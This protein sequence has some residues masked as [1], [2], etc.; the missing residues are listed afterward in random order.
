MEKIY[1]QLPRKE[2]YP[3]ISELLFRLLGLPVNQMPWGEKGMLLKAGELLLS[4]HQELPGEGLRTRVCLQDSAGKSYL[5]Q[6]LEEDKQVLSSASAFTRR[7]QARAREGIFRVLVSAWGQLSPYGVLLGVRPTKLIHHF[8]HQGQ[9]LGQIET[10][11]QEIYCLAPEKVRLLLEVAGPIH[12]LLSSNSYQ[13]GV[14]I[15]LGIPFCPSRC[16]YCSFPSEVI[17]SREGN[18]REYLVALKEEIRQVGRI[19]SHYQ[20]NIYSLYLGGGTPSLL[21]MKELEELLSFLQVAGLS[22]PGKEFTLEAGRPET[23]NREKLLLMR[24]YGV[25]RICINPQTTWDRTLERIGRGHTYAMVE[26]VY[27]CARQLG[28]ESINLDLILGLPGE[29]PLE[30]KASLERIAALKPDHVTVHV[31]ANK[32]RASLKEHRLSQEYIAEMVRYRDALLPEMHL[33]PY[34]LYRQKDTLGNHEN[35]GYAGPNHLSLFNVAMVEEH[36]TVIGLGA[37]AVSKLVHSQTLALERMKNPRLPEEY[38][39]L[40][41]QLLSCKEDRL[42]KFFSCVTI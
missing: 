37:G 31:L 6:S 25:G 4:V 22:L 24:E 32:R 28:F 9:T 1:L 42:T 7:S 34:Y 12:P 15:Y 33:H 8:L 41:P 16:S 19:L 21:P 18:W 38:Q 26:E 5:Y 2:W 39:R 17:S 40:L 27:S 13:Q 10:L 29:G 14:S 3:G 35:V 23:L 20:P 30:V 11:L 36:Q